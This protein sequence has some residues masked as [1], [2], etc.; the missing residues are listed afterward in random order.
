MVGHDAPNFIYI[1]EQTTNT[2]QEQHMDIIDTN[3][4]INGFKMRIINRL[5]RSLPVQD[6]YAYTIVGHL[7]R[8]FGITAQVYGRADVDSI[9]SREISDT[10][11][12]LVR[13]S[14]SWLALDESMSDIE[15]VYDACAEI[16]D[17]IAEN[18]AF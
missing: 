18:L 14:P 3:I 7:R 9:L 16:D 1:P 10:E 15:L 2:Q 13:E 11:W 8:H 17:Y 4:G 5:I 12:M 6:D